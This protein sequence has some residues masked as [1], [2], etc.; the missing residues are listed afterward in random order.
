MI[1]KRVCPFT[2]KHNEMDIPVTQEQLDNWQ[3]GTLIQRAMPTLTPDEREFIMTGIT[4]TEWDKQFNSD[5]D[6]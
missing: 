1:I 3:N 5:E 6:S 4:P 2:Q